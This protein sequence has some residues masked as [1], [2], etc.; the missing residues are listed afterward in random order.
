MCFGSFYG[1]AAAYAAIPTCHQLSDLSMCLLG[2][3]GEETMGE[4]LG[5]TV[6]GRETVTL[7]SLAAERGLL[8]SCSLD[9]GS[10]VMTPQAGGGGDGPGQ[11]KPSETE[12]RC[13]FPGRL[14]LSQRCYLSAVGTQSFQSAFQ[15]P[16]SVETHGGDG[17]QT[18]KEVR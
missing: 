6:C 9:S 7:P 1:F 15:T 12:T 5:K 8:P 3:F 2:R 16:R 13:R 11:N 4:G 18:F 17:P 14:D 10:R